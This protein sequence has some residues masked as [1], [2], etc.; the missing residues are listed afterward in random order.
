MRRIALTIALA[1][2][3]L[4]TF[5]VFATGPQRGACVVRGNDMQKL[6][7]TWSHNWT[8]R[9]TSAGFVPTVYGRVE[10]AGL[11]YNTGADWLLT[12]NEPNLREQANMS[13][14]DVARG[15][16]KIEQRRPNALILAPSIYGDCEHGALNY[17]LV[18]VVQ[19]YLDLYEDMPRFDG[20]AVHAFGNTADDA[21]CW[22]EQAIDEFRGLGYEGEIW[23]A[24]FG[25]WPDAPNKAEFMRRV[26]TY[27]GNT[28]GITRYAWFPARRVTDSAHTYWRGVELLDG[29]GKLTEL[30]RIYARRGE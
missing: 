19:A 8:M 12:F 28:P 3:L 23:L 5:P 29:A 16:R 17:G 9:G 27:I 30:G 10:I 13:A 15:L 22:I 11:A 2:L 18:D 25:A 20:L 26:L 7:A 21:I 1:L 6:G 24:E 4:A 14:Y